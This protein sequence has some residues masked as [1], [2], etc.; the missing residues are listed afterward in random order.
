MSH[1]GVHAAKPRLRTTMPVAVGNGLQLSGL[2]VAMG[3]IFLAG[4]VQAPWS[5]RLAV[6]IA[7]WVIVYH[8]SHAITHWAVGRAVGI[9]FRAFG[10]RGTDHPETYPPGVRQLMSVLPFWVAVT[11]PASLARATRGQRAAMFA[12]G[13]TATS[14]ASLGAALFAKANHAP[15]ASGLLIFAALWVVG[16]T[17]TT[18]LVP[19]GDYAKAIA[20]L[21]AA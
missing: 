1:Q 20:A 11:R 19:K 15:G 18:A 9:Q 16:A 7:G 5:I 8:C 12:A 3:L 4:H 2:V 21:R 13:E 6:V 17:I 10:I 14:V